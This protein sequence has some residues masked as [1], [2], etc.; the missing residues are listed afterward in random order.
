MKTFR[1]IS[2]PGVAVV[3]LSL[4][5]LVYSQTVR[6]VESNIDY[7]AL[8]RAITAVESGGNPRAVGSAGE[9]GLMQIKLQTW[10]DM[11]KKEFGTRIPFTRAF[12]PVLNQQVGQ[13][14]LEHIAALL[15]QNRKKLNDDFLALVVAAYHRG[16]T[17]VE[18]VGF[19]T[20]RLS[21]S[22]REYVERVL[23]LH[24]VYTAQNQMLAMETHAAPIGLIVTAPN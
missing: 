21:P 22:A 1:C 7:P 17:C 2:F 20:R 16:P 18:S 9:R 14:Y 11:T 10:R 15:T 24:G 23:N 12:E 19:T 8:V 6:P 5:P 4:T 13:A 3:C